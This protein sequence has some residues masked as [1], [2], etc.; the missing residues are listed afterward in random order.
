M[1]HHAQVSVALGASGLAVVS[2]VL[3]K[4][5]GGG[6]GFWTFRGEGEPLRGMAGGDPGSPAI[7][8]EWARTLAQ[9]P[10]ILSGRFV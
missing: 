6:L 2:W 9:K 10:R 4:V 3:V 1:E 5:Q 8:A 7:L